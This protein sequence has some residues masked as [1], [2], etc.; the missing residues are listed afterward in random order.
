MVQNAVHFEGSEVE[1][2]DMILK[3]K[4]GKTSNNKGSKGVQNK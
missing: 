1:C 3:A 2:F 4:N